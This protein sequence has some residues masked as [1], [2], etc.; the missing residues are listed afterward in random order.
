MIE[1]TCG[2]ESLVS[3]GDV[4]FAEG[5]TLEEI[6]TSVC[7][8]AELPA[9]IKAAD[10]VKELLEREMV[11]STAV[12]NGIAIPHPRRPLV[13]NSDDCRV[14]VAYLNEPLDM[15]APD[16]RKVYAMFILLSAS[17]QIH[18]KS[19]SSLAAIFRKDGF[20]KALQSRP[21]KA[22]LIELLQQYESAN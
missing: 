19:L 3:R 20:K 22:E 9:G 5:N 21:G 2:V 4:V 12:G 13:K 11:L 10:L 18:I 14:I 16:F 7:N 8:K 1:E 17:S 15:Q 6:F